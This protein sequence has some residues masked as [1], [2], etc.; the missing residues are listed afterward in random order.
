M[1]KVQETESPA[2]DK[3]AVA[4]LTDDTVT[5]AAITALVEETTAAIAAAES[6]ARAEKERAFDPA[7]DHAT[8]KAAHAAMVDASFRCDRLTTLLPR[9]RTCWGEALRREEADA[10]KRERDEFEATILPAIASAR[11]S[12]EAALQTILNYFAQINEFSAA[13]GELLARRPHHLGLESVAEPPIPAATKILADTRLFALENGAQLWP[14]PQQT[15]RLAVA[16][17]QSVLGMVTAGDPDQYSPFWWR[18]AA[19][20]QAAAAAEGERTAARFAQMKRDQEERE[21]R[22]AAENWRA[23]YGMR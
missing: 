17:S 5:S 19:R 12:Y 14:D 6:T 8:A 1:T 4:A 15:N 11:A 13:R 18:A 20:R 9:L 2:L 10:W 3:R 22:E 7:L 16:M 21:N 23:V